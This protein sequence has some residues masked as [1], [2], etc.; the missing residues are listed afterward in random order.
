MYY[1]YNIG[2]HNMRL[3]SKSSVRTVIEA[4]QNE[5]KLTLLIMWFCQDTDR[6]QKEQSCDPSL[7]PEYA[8][9]VLSCI[10]EKMD[11]SVY[12]HYVCGRSK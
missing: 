10:N 2:V 3:G 1:K 5:V 11:Y 9:R 8:E 7:F 4:S 12:R 6:C